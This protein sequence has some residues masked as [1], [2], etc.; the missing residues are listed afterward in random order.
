MCDG[1]FPRV[2]EQWS[3]ATDAEA[4]YAGFDTD[5]AMIGWK[6]RRKEI[7]NYL[8]DPTVLARAL[9]W[10]EATQG[11]YQSCLEEIFDSI[12]PWTAARI[13][14]T[15]CAPKKARVDTDLIKKIPEASDVVESIRGLLRKRAREHSRGACMNPGELVRRFNQLLPECEPGGRL[16]GHALEVFAGKD[17]REQLFQRSR[18]PEARLK[19]WVAV[20]EQVLKAMRDDSKPHE[21]LPEWTSL[22]GAIAAWEPLGAQQPRETL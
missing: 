13:A 5:R 11:W 8:L 17:V 16:R 4:W 7:E 15:A 2:P 1:D 6:W 19:S 21:W 22:R 10:S 18:P 12:G 14:L 20:V 3:S 9:G